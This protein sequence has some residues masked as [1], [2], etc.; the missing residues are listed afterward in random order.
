MVMLLFRFWPPRA[1]Q[2]ATSQPAEQLQQQL[3]QL[4]QQY[5]TTT[6]DLEQR[7]SALEQQI[8]K[9]KEKEEKEAR[10]KS[11]QGAISAAGLA[12]QEAAE[13]AVLGESDQ[14]GAK[15]QGQLP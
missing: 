2:A 15:F 6:R 8:E 11:K 4:K 9:Q 3:L 7:I 1:K 10:E 12:A 5:D 14:V 13:K